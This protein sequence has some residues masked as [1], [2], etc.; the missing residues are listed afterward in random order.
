VLPHGNANIFP[1]LCFVSPA[2]SDSFFLFFSIHFRSFG[3]S[4]CTAPVGGGLDLHRFR[5]KIS[6]REAADAAFP[7][8]YAHSGKRHRQF[9]GG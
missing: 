1:K 5:I 3:L 9:L 6:G 2:F 8:S 7:S 4:W